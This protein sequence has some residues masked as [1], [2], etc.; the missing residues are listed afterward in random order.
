MEAFI[1][2]QL[3]RGEFPGLHKV[4]CPGLVTARVALNTH[5]GYLIEVFTEQDEA[6]AA[7]KKITEDIGPYYSII[8]IT[9]EVGVPFGFGKLA[10]A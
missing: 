5:T 10:P 7:L 4:A 1:I 2:S 9:I 3:Q 6:V 8:P